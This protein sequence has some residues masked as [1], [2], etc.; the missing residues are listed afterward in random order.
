MEGKITTERNKAQMKKQ[1]V[2]RTL[3]LTAIILTTALPALAGSRE[4]LLAELKMNEDRPTTLKTRE[5]EEAVQEM[6]LDRVETAEEKQKEMDKAIKPYYKK[7]PHPKIRNRMEKEPVERPIHVEWPVKIAKQK[8][9]QPAAA[10][11]PAQPAQ[12][13]TNTSA[14]ANSKATVQVS[15]SCDK[16]ACEE[17]AA[18]LK[19]AGFADTAILTVQNTGLKYRVRVYSDST[20]AQELAQQLKV[21]GFSCYIP[22]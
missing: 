2:T 12:T 13:K 19:K 9:P 6:D 11:K 20:P 8:V 3:L 22:K 14:P 17:L 18:R 21:K 7:M 16:K 1:T 10:A 15:A 4:E 5:M